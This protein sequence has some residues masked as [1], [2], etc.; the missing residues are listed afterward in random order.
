MI[1]TLTLS[2]GGCAIATAAKAAVRSRE[3][4]VRAGTRGASEGEREP[5]LQQRRLGSWWCVVLYSRTWNCGAQSEFASDSSLQWS[6]PP[7]PLPAAASA[8]PL[9][10]PPLG[11]AGTG[12]G[13]LNGPQPLGAPR[14][15]CAK[16]PEKPKRLCCQLSTGPTAPALPAAASVHLPAPVG[17][18]GARCDWVNGSV[19]LRGRRHICPP[20]GCERG[21]AVV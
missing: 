3:P 16:I 11:G 9:P 10:A 1:T 13:R 19:P 4:G 12:R 20:A 14:P 7:F 17:A 15:H 2:S 21:G 6:N 5:R 18:T 8:G